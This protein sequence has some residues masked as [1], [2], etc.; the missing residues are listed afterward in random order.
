[1]AVAPLGTAFT[2]E[3][4]KLLSRYC[5]EAI[6]AFDG[7]SAGTEATLKTMPAM[8]AEDIECRV[9]RFDETDDPDSFVRRHGAEAFFAMTEE[10]VP[11]I[12]WALDR[13]LEPAEGTHIERK[14]QA[15]Q[16]VAEILRSVSNRVAWEHYAQEVSRRL[17][18]E[19]KLLK[20]YIQRPN[21]V[22]AEVR[23]AVVDA[24]RP[25]ELPSAE[26]GALTVLLD[27]PQWLESFLT[28]EFDNLLSSAE[29]SSFLNLAANHFRKHG[30]IEPPILLQH[31]E[32]P[33]FRNTVEEALVST[34]KYYSDDDKAGRFYEDC[35]RA[36]KKSWADRT[37]QEIHREL[38]ETDFVSQREQYKEL[39]DR[40]IQVERFKQS[41][42][43]AAG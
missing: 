2:G 28:E 27:R 7:D 5:R 1:V 36:L 39:V 40:Q 43:L 37:L 6:V 34:D 11:V 23:A 18:I 41:L 8:D 33:A 35:I 32:H 12:A 26:F 29:L 31:I 14:L 19:P 21:A 9:V 24:T 42:D 30:R 22:R 3:Q 15:L 17:A 25:M 4:A 13:I 10:A 20:E 38:Q 16:E